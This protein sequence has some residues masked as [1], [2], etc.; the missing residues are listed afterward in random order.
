[1]AKENKSIN[2]WIFFAYGLLFGLILIFGLY[3]MTMY[4]NTHVM[5]T[6]SDA[7]GTISILK[8]SSQSVGGTPV[9]NSEIFK[10]FEELPNKQAWWSSIF[11]STGS[12]NALTLARKVY[13][14]QINAS[15]FNDLIIIY[16]VVGLLAFGLLLV[17]GNHQRKVYYISNLAGGIAIPVFMIIS[18]VFMI[19]KTIVLMADFNK[20]LELYWVTNYAA[21]Q[22]IA[23]ITKD[24]LLINMGSSKKEFLSNMGTFNNSVFILGIVLF[25]I[26]ILYSLWLIATALI[27]YKATAEKRAE[28]IKRAVLNN[29]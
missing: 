27:K 2:K 23:N 17:L 25:T 5:Y 8:T 21:N 14:F 22:D 20:N 1:M 16:A 12:T 15:S 29:D 4:A 3:F 28:V 13:Q 11:G 19:I 7:D 18:S 26:V 24:S 9:E 6:I 10:Y